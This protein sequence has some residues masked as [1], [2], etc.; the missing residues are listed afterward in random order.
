MTS[1][2]VN[3]CTSHNTV[4][5][6]RFIFPNM[7]EDMSN[8]WVISILINKFQ[9]ALGY[10]MVSNVLRT[11]CDSFLEHYNHNNASLRAS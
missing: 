4:H 3:K 10:E 2:L 6:W 7:R 11:E 9:T 5:G 1:L 8:N